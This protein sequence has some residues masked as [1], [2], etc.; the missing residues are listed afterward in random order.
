VYHSGESFYGLLLRPWMP[1]GIQ[2]LA[3]APAFRLLQV[4]AVPVVLLLDIRTKQQLLD[5]LALVTLC[6]ACFSRVHS[7]QWMLWFV[8]LLIV[9]AL[10][11]TDLAILATYDLLTFVYFPLGYDLYD[12]RWPFTLVLVLH[13]GLRVG[14]IAR[15][16]ARLAA[17]RPSPLGPPALCS[18]R[19]APADP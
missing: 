15:V 18:E 19:E 16:A 17:A 14:L 6:F 9:G 4:A 1:G 5:A 12:G 2:A 11:W 3:W 7:P 10:S 8:P 13:A